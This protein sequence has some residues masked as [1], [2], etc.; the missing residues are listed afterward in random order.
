MW[1]LGVVL[2]EAATGERPLPGAHRPVRDLRPGI[3]PAVADLIEHALQSDPGSRPPDGGVALA[4]LAGRATGTDP[5]RPLVPVVAPAPQRARAT[6]PGRRRPSRHRRGVVA[7]LVGA[8]LVAALAGAVVMGGAG[9]GDRGGDAPS[10]ADTTVVASTLVTTTTVVR[11]VA[12]AAPTQPSAKPGPAAEKPTKPGK[13]A[14]KGNGKG[15]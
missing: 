8:V 4:I 6:S 1:S 13:G 3:Q 9:T 10:P 7:L 14:G 2:Y 12:T 5:T 15:G 11:P